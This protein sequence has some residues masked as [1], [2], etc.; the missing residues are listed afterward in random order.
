[1]KIVTFSNFLKENATIY[2]VPSEEELY[3][4]NNT[5]LSAKEIF[6]EICYTII[7]RGILSESNKAQI[8]KSAEILVNKFNDLKYKEVLKMALNLKPKFK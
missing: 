7:G 3:K 1:M 8:V 6:N 2:G 4:F 5:S